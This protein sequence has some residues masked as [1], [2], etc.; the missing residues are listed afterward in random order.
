MAKEMRDERRFNIIDYIKAIWSRRYLVLFIAI[1]VTFGAVAATLMMTTKYRATTA[2]MV[3]QA[4]GPTPGFVSTGVDVLMSMV[5]F[6]EISAL[7]TETY[8]MTS[9][10]NLESVADELNLYVDRRKIPK[11]EY[12]ENVVGP[13]SINKLNSAGEYTIR[14]VNNSG[15][16]NVYYNDDEYVGSG[17][18]GERYTGGGLKFVV[19]G[20]F[21]KGDEIEFSVWDKFALLEY[22]GN[23]AI[24]TK[25]PGPRII[26]ITADWTDRITAKNILK[27]VLEKYL[28]LTS[29]YEFSSME[30]SLAILGEEIEEV[31]REMEQIQD[32]LVK[33]QKEHKTLY[34]GDAISEVVAILSELTGQRIALE[35]QR[36][37]SNRYFTLLVEDK[38]DVTD[39]P[40]GVSIPLVSDDPTLASL[41]T[42]VDTASTEL[43]R[44]KSIY[45]EK[46]PSVKNKE[47]ELKNLKE[48]FYEMVLSNIKS[49]LVGINSQI[50]S[51]EKTF[52]EITSK[53]PKEQMEMARLTKRLTE[54]QSVY[55]VLVTEYERQKIEEIQQR[56]VEKQIRYLHKPYA[57]EDPVSPNK[58]FNLLVGFLFGI[59]L[60]CLVAFVALF[61][62]TSDFERRHRVLYKLIVLPDRVG[63]FFEKVIFRR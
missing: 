42:Q 17:K 4:T 10:R 18:I 21:K 53:M 36:D 52:A 63:K 16:Y 24:T 48:R 51:Y 15:D 43:A 49:R 2:I 55:T 54:L 23:V 56:P 40:F 26:E 44:M 12:G 14:F 28:K 34:Y 25:N 38:I 8:V 9:L 32:E 62:D 20:D 35:I 60:G 3:P 45:T 22:L 7:D 1:L 19:T 61:F 33:Y 27:L 5:G 50:S 11:D 31:N 59:F 46:H 6:G 39:I 30:E 57:Y 29:E 41:K 47:R 13:I 37:L 58:K